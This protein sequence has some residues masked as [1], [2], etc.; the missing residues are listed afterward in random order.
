MG[1][2][3]PLEWVFHEAHYC[4]AYNNYGGYNQ[5]NNNYGENNYTTTSYGAQG[6]ADGGGF[7]PGSQG[8]SQGNKKVV[9]Y[10]G[11]IRARLICSRVLTRKK[12]FGP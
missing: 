9:M 1:I 12:L 6:G 11:T 7:M 4:L 2:I 5:Y 8:G 3:L 10:I